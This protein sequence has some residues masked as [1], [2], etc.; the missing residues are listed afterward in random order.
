MPAKKLQK[1]ENGTYLF[2]N[3]ACV[4]ALAFGVAAIT[5][6]EATDLAAPNCHKG[7]GVADRTFPGQDVAVGGLDNGPSV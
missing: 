7:S 4:G 1:R 2:L 3:V 5:L 6:H